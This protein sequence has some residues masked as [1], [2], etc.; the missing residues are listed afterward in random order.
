MRESVHDKHQIV[1]SDQAGK[2][3][4]LVRVRFGVRQRP[5]LLLTSNFSYD[6][7]NS[8]K[9]I[10]VKKSQTTKMAQLRQTILH[11]YPLVRMVSDLPLWLY[12]YFQTRKEFKKL[13]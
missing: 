3:A 2:N 12:I 1:P 5:I 10:Q 6:C 13:H 9:K 7:T 8:Y 4:A 11:G